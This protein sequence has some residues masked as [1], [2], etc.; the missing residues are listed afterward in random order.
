V[1]ITIPQNYPFDSP[2]VLFET[3]IYHPNINRKGEACLG[4]L[5][6]GWNPSYSI[7]KI[8][9]NI[10]NLLINPNPHDPMDSIIAI[11]Y[12]NNRQSYLNNAKTITKK[13]AMM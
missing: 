8:L 5:G 4:M 1:K 6:S 2:K 10:V 3:V 11:E 9:E 7:D 12:V 13:Y